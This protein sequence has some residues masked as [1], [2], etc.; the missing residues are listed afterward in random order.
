MG[1]VEIGTPKKNRQKQS[2]TN[3]NKRPTNQINKIHVY[4]CKNTAVGIWGGFP[5]LIWS[6]KFYLLAKDMDFFFRI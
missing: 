6:L 1:V 4:I 2:D 3:K 5:Y